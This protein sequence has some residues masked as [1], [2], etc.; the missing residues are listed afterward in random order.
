MI[1][2]KFISNLQQNG[3]FLLV[4]AVFLLSVCLQPVMARAAI[5]D[6]WIYTRTVEHLIQT[7]EMKILHIS[8]VSLVFQAFWG[9]LFARFS[10]N[11]FGALRISTLCIVILSSF[12]MNGTLAELNVPKYWRALGV[13]AYL[14]NPIS[15]VLSF[16]FMTDMHLTSMLVIALYFYIRGIKHGVNH[17]ATCVGSIVTGLAFLIRQPALF[18]F[19]SILLWLGLIRKITFSRDGLKNLASAALPALL[20]MLG[21]TYWLTYFHGIPVWQEVVSKNLTNLLRPLFA[22]LFAAQYLT[23]VYFGFFVLPIS[24]PALIELR[25]TV[26]NRFFL[27]FLICFSIMWTAITIRGLRMPYSPHFFNSAG[28]GPIDLSIGIPPFFPSDQIWFSVIFF[29]GALISIPF[30]FRLGDRLAG[31][32]FAWGWLF[33]LILAGQVVAAMLSSLAFIYSTSIGLERYLISAL[34]IGLIGGLYSL[35]ETKPFL[36]LGWFVIIPLGLFAILGTHDSLAKHQATWQLAQHAN[37]IGIE[38]RHLDGGA[39]W[40]GYY[41]FDNS[42][43]QLSVNTPEIQLSVENYTVQLPTWW[44]VGWAPATDSRYLILGSPI[45]NGEIIATISFPSWLR[46]KDLTL[47]LVKRP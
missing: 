21:Y 36:I 5:N 4:V 15:Y 31:G 30:F 17:W 37:S 20:I 1:Y 45:H 6:D 46:R 3:L 35:R 38:N 29:I 25:T 7:G 10:D 13:A 43:S 18:F 14:F 23:I 12:F 42:L 19:I 40:D 34:S 11:I 26:K 24:L 44:Q 27:F 33:I 28:L 39:S 41:L 9:M 47:Y 16:T 32:Q 22:A 8:V 2:K